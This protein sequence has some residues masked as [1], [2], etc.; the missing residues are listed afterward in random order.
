[1]GRGKKA[2]PRRKA[3]EKRMPMQ[4]MTIVAE[5]V[6]RTNLTKAEVVCLL[7]ELRALM[8]EELAG[9]GAPGVFPFPE[10]GFKAVLHD[11]PALPARPGRNPATGETIMLKPRPASKVVKFRPMKKLKDEVEGTLG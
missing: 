4:Q 3:A 11:R 6:Q 2:A 5:L 10:M 1:M 8:V 9:R 7:A